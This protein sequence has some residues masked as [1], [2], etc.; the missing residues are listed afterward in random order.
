MS[1][2]LRMLSLLPLLAPV[3]ASYAEVYKWVDEQ[4]KVHYG[5][6]PGNARSQPVQIQAAPQP[7]PDS[8]ERREKSQ[9]LLNEYS[10]DQT[11][12]KKQQESREKEAAQRKVNCELAKKNLD[13]YEHAATLYTTDK[14]GE[15]HN[16][17]DDEYKK[18]IETSHANV[19]K[20]C[21]E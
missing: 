20:W 10:D 8:A 16:L 19:K 4:G 21:D 9:K 7:D 2:W 14:D 6:H 12:Q 3:T 1:S 5:D 15:R 18:A 17:T 13:T 11:E